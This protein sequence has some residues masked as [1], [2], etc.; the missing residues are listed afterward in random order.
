MGQ[1]LIKF[2][3]TRVSCD[4]IV[5]PI[6]KELN[7]KVIPAPK[8]INSDFTPE[9]CRKTA[10]STQSQWVLIPL[11]CISTQWLPIVHLIMLIM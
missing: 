11:A 3:L 7:V 4:D 9:N 8:A 1:N 5:Y 2:L 6:A 10:G